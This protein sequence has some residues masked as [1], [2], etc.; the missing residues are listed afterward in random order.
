MAVFLF[1]NNA[2]TTL[3]GPIASGATSLSLAAGTGGIYPNPVTGQQFA[4]TLTS[5]AS[6]SVREIVYCTAR[7][8][9]VCTI[10]RGQESTSP[11][12]FIAGDFVDNYFTAGTAAQ[13]VQAT[14]LQLQA[15]NYAVDTGA[16]NAYVIT[17]TPGPGSL[18]LTTGE[19]IR[20]KISHSNTASST[21]ADTGL[22]ATVIKNPDGTTLSQ[23]QLLLGGIAE[24]IFDGTAYQLHSVTGNHPGTPTEQAFA[25]SGSYTAPVGV[26]YARVRVWGAGGGGGSANGSIA[27]GSGGGGAGYAEGIV[28]LVPGT[29]YPVTVGGA[30]A[31]N[32]GNGGNSSFNGVSATGGTGGTNQTGAGGPATQGQGGT[33]AGGTL[34]T[35][36]SRGGFGYTAGGSTFISGVGGSSFGTSLSIINVAGPSNSIAGAAGAYPGGGGAGGVGVAS[37][38]SGGAGLVIIETFT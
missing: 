15:G 1:A 36:G 6:A 3:A 34:N 35:V 18:A 28:S 24:F 27:F 22:P 7:S 21:L 23:N 17:R 37:G 11:T 29:V 8:A 2:R 16:A 12:A 4:M 5:Q 33:G 25:S 19:P 30:G 26:F 9:D 38:G 32:G 14:Q 13:L 31:A 20:V 10:I